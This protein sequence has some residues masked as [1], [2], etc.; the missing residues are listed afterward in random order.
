[1]TATAVLPDT[2]LA[3]SLLRTARPRQW[4]KNLLV[5]AVP[6]ASGALFTTGALRGVLLAFV[7][8]TLAAVGTYFINDAA[9]VEADRRHPVKRHRP[10]AAGELG[11]SDARWIGYGSAIA[12]LGLAVA[13]SWSFAACVA[14][15]LAL[16]AAYSARLKHV[17]VLDV[18]I[19]AGGFLL[20]AVGG[21]AATATSTS[22]WFLLVILLGSLYLVIAK[23]IGELNRTAQGAPGRRVLAGYSAPWLQQI[24]SMTLSGT[25]L[26]YAAWA[27]PYLGGDVALPL[28]AASLVPFL[29]AL[30]RYSLLVAHGAGEAPE[31]VLT[32]DIFLIGSGLLWVAMAGGA[33]YLA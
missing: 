25:V 4:I 14:A 22:N 12:A 1:M 3:S 18:L 11:V 28:L 2:S 5:V 9:D 24:S 6:G 26:A 23:R 17:P 15:Y 21:G 32:S 19:V 16:T 27:F 31:R 33:L 13:V 8:F 30:M 29:A 20:R 10:I 7:A